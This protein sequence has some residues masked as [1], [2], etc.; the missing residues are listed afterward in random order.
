MSKYTAAVLLLIVFIF[1]AC[2]QD[3]QAAKKV[4]GPIIE[5]PKSKREVKTVGYEYDENKLTYEL[6][7]SDEFNY[8]GPPD[9]GNGKTKPAETDGVIMKLHIIPKAT[10]CM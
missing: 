7:W 9:P 4:S 3:K 6:V 8:T 10:M 2:R 5:E 1:G